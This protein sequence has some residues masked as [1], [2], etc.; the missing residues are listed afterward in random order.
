MLEKFL[1]IFLFL[2]ADVR[3]ELDLTAL[4]QEIKSFTSEA[5]AHL[6]KL[7]LANNE[8]ANRLLTIEQR[9]VAPTGGYGGDFDGESLGQKVIDSEGFKAM[10]ERGAKSTGAIPIRNFHTKTA[11][12]NATGASQPLVPAQRLAGIITTAQPR[13]TIRDLLP[14]GADQQQSGRVRQ[15]TR[16]YE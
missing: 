4:G 15:G 11:V 9:M 10:L 14:S 6:E 13:L 3:G 2:F 7:A 5:K 16:G 12:V 8:T 1:S